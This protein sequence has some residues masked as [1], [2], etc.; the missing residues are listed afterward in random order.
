MCAH[1]R[2]S[3]LR[4][5]IGQYIYTI[6]TRLAC[7]SLLCERGGHDDF[8]A[9]RYDL[10]SHV[11]RYDSVLVTALRAVRN[12]RAGVTVLHGESDHAE[13]CAKRTQS[14]MILVPR[15]SPRTSVTRPV[16]RPATLRN[17]FTKQVEAGT[18]PIAPELQSSFGRWICRYLPHRGH[19]S[20]A[21]EKLAG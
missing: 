5:Q 8:D 15:W 17:T 10:V 6:V 19:A 21:T 9:T 16:G 2:I 4:H 7:C 20:A 11:A 13:H 3:G 14:P 18:M 12:L 1:A